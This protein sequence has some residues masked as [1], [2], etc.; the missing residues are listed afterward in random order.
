MQT[1]P[2][3]VTRLDE[4]G[5]TRVGDLPAPKYKPGQCWGQDVS[6]AVIETVTE[7]VVVSQAVIAADGTVTSPA[8]YRTETH[9]KIVRKRA[10]VWFRIPCDG[11]MTP[12]LVSVLQRALKARGYYRGAI[13]GEMDNKTANAIQAFQR[14]RGLDS[15]VFSLAAA[16]QLGIIAIERPS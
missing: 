15:P 10:D 4:P 7:Q 13:T 11:E 9:Q 5:L 16:H 6:P 12:E 8:T 1:T 3:E 14:P 2:G